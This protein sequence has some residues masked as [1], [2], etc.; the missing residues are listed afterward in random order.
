ML[1]SVLVLAGE[2]PLKG[3]LPVELH[4]A[5]LLLCERGGRWGRRGS[6]GSWSWGGLDQSRQVV[7]EAQTIEG[8]WV[9][10]DVR[11]REDFIF[12]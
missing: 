7:G 5:L 9:A 12:H 1:T 2:L 8:I 4:A 10:Q 3:A 11:F 6:W